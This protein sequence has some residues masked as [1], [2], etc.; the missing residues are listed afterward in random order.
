MVCDIWHKY[1][2]WYF[3]IVPNFTRLTAREIIYNNYFEISLVVFMPNITI[4]HAITSTNTNII[5]KDWRMKA[6]EEIT[7]ITSIHPKILTLNSL[8]LM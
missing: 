6:N 4:N 1:H 5:F 7:H 2:L 3:K 8:A